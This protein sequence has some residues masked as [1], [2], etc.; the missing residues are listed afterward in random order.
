MN[1]IALTD[2]HDDAGNLESLR[3]VL[4][5]ADLLLLCGDLTHFGRAAAAERIMKAARGINP[6]TY[7][8]A[9]N[10]DRPEAARFLEQEGCSLHARGLVVGGIGFVGVGASLPCHVRTPNEMSE[11][12]FARLLSQGRGMIPPGMP[13]VLVAHQPPFGTLNDQLADGRHVGSRSIR[14]FIEEHQPV[15]CFTGHIHEGVGVD[16]IGPT[17]IVNPGPFRNGGYAA[18]RIG[19]TLEALEIRG[20]A[21]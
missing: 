17:R 14:R 7:A 6:R 3:S 21:P 12:D 19:D 16:A 2:L 11:D 10:C 1:V 5:A 4:A 18:A 8:V 20:A 15:V 9:G 13:L